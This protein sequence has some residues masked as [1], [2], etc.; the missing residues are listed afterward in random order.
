[1]VFAKFAVSM[2]LAVR[3]IYRFLVWTINK[4]FLVFN[5]RKTGHL[6]STHA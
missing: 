5:A 3:K 1:M 2:M 4:M 6:I